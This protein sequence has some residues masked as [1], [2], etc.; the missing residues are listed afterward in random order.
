ME[1]ATETPRQNLGLFLASGVPPVLWLLVLFFAPLALIW[2]YSFGERSGIID[3]VITWTPDNYKLTLDPIYT[4]IFLRS[5][6]F[7]VIT[8]ALCLV[9]GFPV[10]MVI[11]FADPKRQPI[12]LL[13][14]I[15]PFWT[16]LLI[17]TFALHRVLGRNG[18][19][20]WIWKALHARIDQALR[21]LGFDGLGPFQ[22]LDLVFN[23]FAVIF[24]LTYVALPFMVLPLYASL[25]RLNRQHLEASLDL[26]ANQ[27]QTF[28]RVIV[29]LSS[30]G[31][32][33]GILITF[34]PTL[35]SF[36][37]PDLLGGIDSKMIA[38]I[39]ARQFSE[40]NN[41][42]FGSALSYMLVYAT[43]FLLALQAV[44]SNARERRRAQASSDAT[45]GAPA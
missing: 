25:E 33:S 3:I 28:F 16:N 1:S 11:A 26:G 15:L 24:G 45:L 23:D 31:I 13:L 29:P 21:W 14:I 32:F 19:I 9:I 36:L 6:R 22:P 41:W 27:L 20:N 42:P 30:A 37:T 39:I 18:L 44:V 17:R 7:T 43:F 35:G 8:T 12:L 5:L 34:I 10:A 40:A 38:T 2:G 4:K